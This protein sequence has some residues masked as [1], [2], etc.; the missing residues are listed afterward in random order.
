M[1]NVLQKLIV[2]RRVIFLA[3]LCVVP[4]VAAQ[5]TQYYERCPT[6]SVECPNSSTAGNRLLFRAIVGIEDP[7]LRFEWEIHGNGSI[8]GGQGTSEIT[9][10]GNAERSITATLHVRGL[11]PS[12]PATASCSLIICRAPVAYLFDSYRWTPTEQVKVQP[13]KTKKRR[14]YR[15]TKKN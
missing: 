5:S 3:A 2:V 11:D 4:H 13:S 10:E 15:T 8:V 12:C 9:V 14:Q 6:I 7:N 1:R